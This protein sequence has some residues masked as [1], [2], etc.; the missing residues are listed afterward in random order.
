MV[1]VISHMGVGLL[2]GLALSLKGDKLRAV[3]LLSVLPD[4]DYILYSAFVFANINLSPENRNQLFYLIGH[5]EFMHSILFILLITSLLWFRTKNW[6]F[7]V[8]GFQSLF[9][10][11]YLDY[12]TSWKMRPL[13]PFSTDTS[14]MGAVYFFDPLLN[15]LPV[16]PLFIVIIGNLSHRRIIKGKIKRFCTF[17]ANIDDKL[18]ASLIILLLFWLALMPISKAFLINNISLTEETEISYQSTYPES[19]NRFLTAYSYNSTH[20]KVLKIS[21]LSGIEESSYVE[22][23]SVEG[24]ISD[25]GAYVKRAEN[26]YRAG[27]SQEIDYPIYKVSESNDTVTVVLSDARNPYLADVAYFKSFYRFVFDRSSVEYEVYAGMYGGRE[28]RLGRNWFG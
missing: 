23:V 22:K 8:G 1:N 26:L 3:V 19:V 12:V 16:L 7:T 13:Y 18:Y 5:R 14:I 25:S 21:Y 24:N 2:I 4:L 15:L 20:Y 6:L 10:H 11:S 9:F 27:V 17:I 28:E